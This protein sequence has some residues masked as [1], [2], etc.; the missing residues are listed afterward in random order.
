MLTRQVIKM[1][2]VDKFK[3]F[4]SVLLKNN[5]NEGQ[6]FIGQNVNRFSEKK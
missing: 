2:D 5:D 3:N 6:F 4:K 1:R